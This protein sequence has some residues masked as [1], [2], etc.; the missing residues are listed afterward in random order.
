MHTPAAGHVATSLS[1]FEQLW[2][3]REIMRTEGQ[4]LLALVLFPNPPR[5]PT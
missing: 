1:R 5:K 4:A 2:L 3:A